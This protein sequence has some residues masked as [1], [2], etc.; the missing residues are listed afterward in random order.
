MFDAQDDAVGVALAI[1]YTGKTHNL[2]RINKWTLDE[3]DSDGI[4]RVQADRDRPVPFSRIAFFGDGLTDIPCMRV[5]TDHG[6]HAVAVYDPERPATGTAAQRLLD[7]GRARLAGPG[8]YREG[9]HLD[10]LAHDM[11]R[12]MARGVRA[13]LFA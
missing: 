7:D 1:N 4:N 5:V 8:D 2:F 6:G 10:L 11:L 3:W 13:D 9:A 12:E